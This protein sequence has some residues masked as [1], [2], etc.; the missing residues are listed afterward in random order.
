MMKKSAAINEN[1]S[2]PNKFVNHYYQTTYQKSRPSTKG[3]T[4]RNIPERV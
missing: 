4:K 1:E 2:T 3:V